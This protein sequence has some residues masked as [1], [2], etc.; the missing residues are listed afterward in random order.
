M[1][2]DQLIEAMHIAWKFVPFPLSFIVLI[3]L[4]FAWLGIEYLITRWS[5]RIPMWKRPIPGLP[6]VSEIAIWLIQLSKLVF[7]LWIILF[8]LVWGTIWIDRKSGLP[9]EFVNYVFKI[10]HI[11]EITYSYLS[12]HIFRVGAR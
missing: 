7:V 6:V 11:W 5:R 10:A 3:V 8:S 12:R 1:Q 9:P 4:S 2:S